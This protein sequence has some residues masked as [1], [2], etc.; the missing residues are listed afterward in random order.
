MAITSNLYTP[1]VSDTL[2]SFVRTKTCRIY[3]SL[4]K[5]NSAADI[6]NVQISLINQ[7]T[8]LSAFNTTNYPSGIKLTTMIF[9]S[10][11]QDDYNYYIEI[12]VTDLEEKAFGLNQFYKVQLRF[13]SSQAPNPPSNGQQLASWIYNNTQY[14]SEWSKVCLIKGIE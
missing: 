14:F 13:T 9:D 7:K 6:K 1:L 12:P 2:P 3:F 11:I 8:N 4:S 10:S 5:Y